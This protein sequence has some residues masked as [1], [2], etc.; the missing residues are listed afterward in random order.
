MLGFVFLCVCVT[1]G[2]CMLTQ[3]QTNF[4]YVT[5]KFYVLLNVLV[6]VTIFWTG[7]TSLIKYI[8]Q[9]TIGY[10][11]IDCLILWTLFFY[12]KLI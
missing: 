4:M 1:K 11:G 10:F 9:N 12:F 8:G 5:I 2:A 6:D 7:L 3:P